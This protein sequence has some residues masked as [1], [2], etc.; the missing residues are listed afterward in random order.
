MN[1]QNDIREKLERYLAGVAKPARYVGGE[2]NI[3]RKN[4]DEQNV[5]VC[6]AFPDVYDIGQSYIG[7]HI[8]YHI[9]NKRT[10]TLCERSFAPWPDMEAVMRREGIPLWS[11]E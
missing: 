4:P 6:L 11:V 7:F 10:G 2:L 3:I 1:L 5:R 8:L 9:L